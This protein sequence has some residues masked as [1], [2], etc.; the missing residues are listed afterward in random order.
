MKTDS[1]YKLLEDSNFN[2]STDSRKIAGDEIFFAIKGENFDGNRFAGDALA[3]G[4][5]LAVIDDS[6]YKTDNTVVVEDVTREL[7]NLAKIYRLK[8]N[9]P[10]LAITGSNGKT[11]TKEL[12]ARVL[13]KGYNIHYTRGNLNNHL[14]VPL[15]ILS[16]KADS[17]FM[18]IEMG[19]NHKGEIAEL[20]EIAQPDYGLITNIGK[21]HL[22]GF[23][24]LE[25]VIEAKSELYDYLL[26]NK[27]A[28][29]YNDKNDL[30]RSI[31][32]KLNIKAIPYSHPGKNKLCVKE[33]KQGP[34]LEV[35]ID[36]NKEKYSIETNLFGL[37][38]LENVLAAIALGLYFNIKPQK[39]QVSIESYMPDNNRSQ[40]FKTGKN[41][42]ICDSYNA[43]PV[44]MKRSIES[45]SEYPADR[46]LIILGDMFEL[47]Q[48][49][50]REH[51]DLL[52]L[53]NEIDKFDIILVG[54][55]F[56]SLAEKYNMLSFRSSE[57]L[58]QFLSEN[59]VRN[60]HVLI[61]GSRAMELEKIYGL[62]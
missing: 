27:G 8:L 44:S 40:I 60:S 49:S 52:K 28:V 42:L 34:E 45:F 37:H 2:L 22:E 32:K 58:V 7:Q 30:L 21:A 56:S 35:L 14:G 15:T 23:G 19:A 47:G 6:K 59:P 13:A 3:R 25:A 26:R 48:Y 31:I 36:I 46:K 33:V 11:T 51:E 20:C 9:I 39:I 4:A 50:N 61:K 24:S 62:M 29:F 38:N 12:L 5:R 41:V 54:S 18:I 16:C 43:N 53:V 57:E 1:L 55:I 17:Q 10:V